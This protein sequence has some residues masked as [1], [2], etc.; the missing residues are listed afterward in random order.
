MLHGAESPVYRTRV[1][2]CQH[3]RIAALPYGEG[4]LVRCLVRYEFPV[5]R[6]VARSQCTCY[7]GVWRGIPCQRDVACLLQGRLGH[8]G[9]WRAVRGV[10]R[11]VAFPVYEDEPLGI[12]HAHLRAL[13]RPVRPVVLL[14]DVER[15]CVV[16]HPAAQGPACPAAYDGVYQRGGIGVARE[17]A[18]CVVGD[19]VAL[20]VARMAYVLVV[21]T[22]RRAQ[23]GDYDSA[24]LVVYAHYALV[25]LNGFCHEVSLV[26]GGGKEYVRAVKVRVVAVPHAAMYLQSARY[27]HLHL[28]VHAHLAAAHR[29]HVHVAG[30][31]HRH[32]LFQ[33]HPL[34]VHHRLARHPHYLA[35]LSVVRQGQRGNGIA[36]GIHLLGQYYRASIRVWRVAVQSQGGQV[37]RLL[38]ACPGIVAREDG[39][40]VCHA[41]H[42]AFRVEGE[43][44][45]SVTAH[46]SEA[47]VLA[48]ACQLVHYPEG[49]WRAYHCPAISCLKVVER[50]VLRLGQHHPVA[51]PELAVVVVEVV[52]PVVFRLILVGR[53]VGVRYGSPVHGCPAYRTGIPLLDGRIPRAL[54]IEWYGS[55]YVIRL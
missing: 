16:V 37:H 39:V 32:Q 52:H 51:Q 35:A 43:E 22:H 23:V 44:A 41:E 18:R 1:E 3:S 29:T 7:A 47:Q 4:H 24:V 30:G 5:V 34:G 38:V 42:G 6:Q 31:V 14:K 50:G 19:E 53:T 17:A 8:Y 9:V 49:V 40:V 33:C 28:V 13:R 15:P 11:H 25:V 54:G 27:L 55:V 45:V 12:L 36:G 26:G 10:L 48:L 20:P 2:W 21:G 46:W